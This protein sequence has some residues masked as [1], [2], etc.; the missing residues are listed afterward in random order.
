MEKIYVVFRKFYVVL[1]MGGI[2]E[3]LDIKKGSEH[4]NFRNVSH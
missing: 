1:R 3:E 4:G 2:V